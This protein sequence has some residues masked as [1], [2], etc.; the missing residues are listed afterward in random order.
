ETD[1]EVRFVKPTKLQGLLL[2]CRYYCKATFAA[3]AVTTTATRRRR[4]IFCC[5]AVCVVDTSPARSAKHHPTRKRCSQ[6]ATIMASEEE[7]GGAAGREGGG[8]GGEGEATEAVRDWSEMTPACLTLV[9]RRLSLEDRWKGAM[10]ACRSWR[11]A[12]RDPSLFSCFDLEPSFGAEGGCLSDA[13][14]WWTP[15]FRRRID[16][17]L[18][19]AAEWSGGSLCE[20]RVRHCSDAS[21]SFAVER[22]PNLQIL[23]I[24]S[25][26]SVT[27]SSMAKIASFCPMLQE[28]DISHCYEISFISL[29]HIGRA[30]PNLTIL[31]RNLL[32]WLDPSQHVSVVPADYLNACPQDG[33]REAEAVAKFMPNLKHLEIRFSKLTARG[34]NLISKGCRELVFLDLF[35]CANLTSRAIE[36]ASLNLK[37]LE[38]LVKPN[39]YIPRSVF[40]TE[41]YGH[42]RLYDERFQTNVFQI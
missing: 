23:S 2:C 32:N 24:R 14:S 31:K 37:N 6:V 38:S 27:D 18:R 26:Q 4:N 13:S 7:E 22:S 12:A 28:I 20:V 11:D 39:F 33:D 15:E 3:V 9:F 42:W 41:R 35:G 34:V 10:R 25:S 5:E 1:I 8:G 30:C 21:L 19:S 16:S 36:Q 29:E 40:H 17:M